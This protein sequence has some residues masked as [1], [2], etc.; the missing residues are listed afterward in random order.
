MTKCHSLAL[1][2]F[3]YRVVSSQIAGKSFDEYSMAIAEGKAMTTP[4][5][6][7]AMTALGNIRSGRAHLSATCGTASRQSYEAGEEADAFVPAV[8]DRPAFP[9]KNL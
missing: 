7:L 3:P 1:F 9:H 2:L 6:T 4:L 8:F 5:T